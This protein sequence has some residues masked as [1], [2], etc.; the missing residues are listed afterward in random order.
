M[1]ALGASLFDSI[2]ANGVLLCYPSAATVH[3]EQGLVED[4][5]AVVLGLVQVVR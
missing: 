4:L 3:R 5:I 2:G 1:N